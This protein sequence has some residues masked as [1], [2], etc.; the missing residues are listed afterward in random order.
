MPLISISET[1]FIPTTHLNKYGKE[2]PPVPNDGAY[3]GARK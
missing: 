2:Y 1:G 3:P